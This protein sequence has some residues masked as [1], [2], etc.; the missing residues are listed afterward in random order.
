MTSLHR[1]KAVPQFFPQSRL[2]VEGR[3]L[4]DA[5]CE[6][7]PTFCAHNFVVVPYCSSD[8]WLGSDDRR[9]QTAGVLCVMRAWLSCVAAHSLYLNKVLKLTRI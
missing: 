5:D 6:R 2:V 3:D 1:Y 4:L 8:L 7:N 9:F